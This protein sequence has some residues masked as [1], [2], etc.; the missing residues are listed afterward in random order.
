VLGLGLVGAAL[1]ISGPTAL[2]TGFLMPAYVCRRLGIHP[3]E[4]LRQGLLVPLACAVPFSMA[5]LASRLA[6]GG[7]PLLTLLC[8]AL[9]GALVLA[10]LY[11]RFLLPPGQRRAMTGRL[12]GSVAPA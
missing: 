7:Q 8:G 11:W 12:R 6:F 2:T 10:P 5:L 3:S 1:A 4:F 9:V